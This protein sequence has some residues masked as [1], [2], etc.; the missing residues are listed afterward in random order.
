MPEVV[1]APMPATI[2]GASASGEVGAP[3]PNGTS[4]KIVAIQVAKMVDVPDSSQGIAM[5][6]Y[7]RFS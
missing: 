3:R 5:R 7:I 6:K 4:A 1:I 2:S